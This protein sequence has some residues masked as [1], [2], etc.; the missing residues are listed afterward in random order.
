MKDQGRNP[1]VGVLA[2]S[3]AQVDALAHAVRSHGYELLAREV[4][5]NLCSGWKPEQV[6][7][8]LADL[9]EQDEGLLDVLLETGSPVLLGIEHAPQ[10]ATQA[11]TLWERRVYTKLRGMV[12]A[13]RFDTGLA[14]LEAEDLKPGAPSL[15]TWSQEYTLNTDLYV[16][17]LAA[18]LGGPEA[19]KEFLD[20]LPDGLPVAFILAQHIDGRMLD[21]LPRVLGRHNH[22]RIRIAAEGD[23]LRPAEVLIA[24][25]DQEMDFDDAGRVHL[26][27]RPWQ[28]PYAPSMDQVLANVSRSFGK[29][30]LAVI[31][32]GMGSDGSMSG[33]NLIQRGGKIM[34]QDAASCAC[35][36]QP[37]SMRATGCVSDNGRPSELA[38]KIVDYMKSFYQQNSAVH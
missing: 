5:R 1:R 11:F 32:S 36:S 29:Q 22:F 28:G 27:G 15:L 4:I 17:V 18:S 38:G 2:G 3:R 8:W 23:E 20:S 10:P 14:A 24:P 35:S 30:S 25:V 12:G 34:A 7:V 21:I 31:F 26:C 19:V 9:G 33:P 16:C 6:D 13:P 37:D